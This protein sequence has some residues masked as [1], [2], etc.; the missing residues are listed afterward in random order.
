M[1]N[2]WREYSAEED[3]IDMVYRYFFEKKDKNIGFFSMIYKFKTKT[4]KII[5]LL[6][7]Y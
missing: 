4:L 6:F 5:S 7:Y 1:R 2:Q 3:V